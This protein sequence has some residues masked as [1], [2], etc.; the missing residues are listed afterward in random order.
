MSNFGVKGLL[1]FITM[2]GLAVM[3][4][5]AVLN[6]AALFNGNYP[7]V[8]S[9]YN[10]TALNVWT[11]IPQTLKSKS[12]PSRISQTPGDHALKLYN[13]AQPDEKN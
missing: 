3:V 6:A 2:A 7:A 11:G 4:G 9:K 12:R 13:Q 8:Y 1:N 5:G 10:V